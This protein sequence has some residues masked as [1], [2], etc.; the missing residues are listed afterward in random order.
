MEHKSLAEF[1]A[2]TVKEAKGLHEIAVQLGQTVTENEDTFIGTFVALKLRP[3]VTAWQAHAEVC[4][5]APREQ[6]SFELPKEADEFRGFPRQAKTDLLVANVKGT[7]MVD[8]RKLS[9][10]APPP[11]FTREEQ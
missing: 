8:G 1:L 4:P 6:Q 11:F 9:P 3:L 10:L 2:S 7:M 5:T